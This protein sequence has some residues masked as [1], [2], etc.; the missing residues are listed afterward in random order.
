MSE[1]KVRTKDTC[2]SVG[3]IYNPRELPGV[4]TVS[5]I[6]DRV[7]HIC[8]QAGRGEAIFILGGASASIKMQN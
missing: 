5:P 6:V 2:W 1:Y 4:S 8:R 3:T 7:L